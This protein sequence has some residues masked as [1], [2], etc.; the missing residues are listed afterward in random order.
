MESFLAIHFHDG[1]RLSLVPGAELD[2]LGQRLDAE[3]SPMN[4]FCDWLF[5]KHGTLIGFR[6]VINSD[7]LSEL[8]HWHLKS[9]C[10]KSTQCEVTLDRDRLVIRW[11]LQG[12]ID[13][14]KSDFQDF[15]DNHVFR[16]SGGWAPNTMPFVL[17]AP[18]HHLEKSEIQE[19]MSS[20]GED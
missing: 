1:I 12:E 6:H 5:S 18:L 10:Y 14:E 20:I 3:I 8:V 7:R 15:G 19:L 4:G 2:G 16:P 11:N 13:Q 17:T 9:G